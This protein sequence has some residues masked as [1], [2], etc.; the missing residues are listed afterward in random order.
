MLSL[1]EMERINRSLEK[2]GK[3]THAWGNYPNEEV[4][5]CG[6]RITPSSWVTIPA[7]HRKGVITCKGCL[8]AIAN[9]E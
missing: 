2:E 1:Q 4:A 7:P 6:H 3:R 8:K 5:P 9:D